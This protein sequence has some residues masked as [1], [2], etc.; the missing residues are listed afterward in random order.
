MKKH[1]TFLIHILSSLSKL[2]NCL[3]NI[4]TQWVKKSLTVAR[5]CEKEA[6][7]DN[8]WAGRQFSVLDQSRFMESWLKGQSARATGTSTASR[9]AVP[10]Q[11]LAELHKK[12][13]RQEPPHT[14]ACPGNQRQVLHCQCQA[15]PEPEPSQVF[16]LDWRGGEELDRCSFQVKVNFCI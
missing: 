13:E 6:T 2:D 7:V 4:N 11:N 16:Y 9:K 1:F 5:H 14:Q 8:C 10:I 15:T 3:C 12:S